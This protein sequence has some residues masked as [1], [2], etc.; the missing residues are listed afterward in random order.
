MVV[1][2]T[3]RENLLRVLHGQ[4]P[5]WVPRFGSRP[6]DADPGYPFAHMQVMPAI[7]AGTVLPNGGRTDIFGVEYEP[8]ESAGGEMLPKPGKFILD[9]ISKWRD[10]IKVPSLEG[11]D[12]EDMAKK[13]TEHIDRRVTAVSMSTGGGYFQLL[14]NFM[15]FTE[16]LCALQEEPDM[17]L[18]LLEYLSTFYETVAKNLIDYIKPDLYNI[19]DDNATARSPFISREMYQKLFKPYHTRAMQFAIDRGLPINMHNCGRCEDFIEDWRDFHVS[20]WN[21]AQVMNDLTGIKEKY[22]N[23]L[24][25][26][27][28]WDSSG[29]AGWSGSSEEFVRSEVR[30]CIDTFAPG[31]GFCFWASV[32]GPKDNPEIYN[33]SRWIIDEY[34]KYGRTFYQRLG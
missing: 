13:A 9:D 8:T 32:L 7:L 34:N 22:G 20:A 1:K 28:C 12:W 31:G 6:S 14:T 5:G 27:G 4:E 29:P 16:G 10:I 15:G 26:I 25:L 3:E 2:M 19:G 24:V 11:I 23:S 18:E 17:V 33:R 21:P 30:R